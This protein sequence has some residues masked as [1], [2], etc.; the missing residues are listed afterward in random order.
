MI[1]LLNATNYKLLE[2]DN[3]K[4]VKSYVIISHAWYVFIQSSMPPN[5][6]RRLFHFVFSTSP[7]RYPG[8]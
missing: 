4:Q 8:Q 2:D 5:A 3:P 7:G 6:A 1:R